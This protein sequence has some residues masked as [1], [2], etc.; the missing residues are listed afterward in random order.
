MDGGRCG[1]PDCPCERFEPGD[2]LPAP[3]YEEAFL[4]RRACE[5]RQN[6]DPFA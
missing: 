3:G 1:V 4:W 5:A 2:T 6:R